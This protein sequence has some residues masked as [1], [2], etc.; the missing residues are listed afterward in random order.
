MTDSTL[1]ALVKYDGKNWHYW[2]N[3]TQD[4]AFGYQALPILLGNEV[5]PVQPVNPVID[6]GGGGQA[7]AD[8]VVANQLWEDT[9]LA[10]F[11]IAFDK[12][13]YKN[14]KLWVYL[15]FTQTELTQSYVA[16]IPR[17]ACNLYYLRLR[18]FEVLAHSMAYVLN[19]CCDIST[20]TWKSGDNGGLS[21]LI[22]DCNRLKDA[23]NSVIDYLL[24]YAVP[25]GQVRMTIADMIAAAVCLSKVPPSYKMTVENLHGL[26]DVCWVMIQEHLVAK[27]IRLGYEDNTR[28]HA[29]ALAAVALTTNSGSPPTNRAHHRLSR[30]ARGFKSKYHTPGGICTVP[31]CLHP[32]GHEN[33]QCFT[34]FPELKAE[35]HAE[36]HNGGPKANIAVED[37]P[38]EVFEAY[39]AVELIDTSILVVER[40]QQSQDSFEENRG[41]LK[42]RQWDRWEH[43]S[44]LHDAPYSWKGAEFRGLPEDC[45]A[46]EKGELNI[47]S[48]QLV[49]TTGELK[50]YITFV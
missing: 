17:G 34:A 28:Q 47:P 1:R 31:G 10:R 15:T 30:P 37:H 44:S 43:Q 25:V 6:P 21:I 3:Q 16:G 50:S 24:N 12:F 7:H 9:V 13:G 5:A 33:S 32:N 42:G 27:S 36:L 2:D 14:A 20:I 11:Q 46:E 4:I 35:Y 29:E 8:W 40:G 49:T 22:Q 45:L 48:A 39:R 38:W 26:P 18:S 19:V 23:L 41:A